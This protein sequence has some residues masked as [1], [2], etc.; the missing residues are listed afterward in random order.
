M[1]W[2]LLSHHILSYRVKFPGHINK[3]LLSSTS[4]PPRIKQQVLYCCFVPCCN[5]C[6]LVQAG[7]GR[8]S[9]EWVSSDGVGVYASFAFTLSKVIS[10]PIPRHH[11]FF[12]TVRWQ[13]TSGI[14]N[15]TQLLCLAAVD[16]LHDFNVHPLPLPQPAPLLSIW[17]ATGAGEAVAAAGRSVLVGRRTHQVAERFDPW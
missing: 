7:R 9:R 5:A 8:F 10:R 11:C 13:T 2:L 6:K 15:L 4:S 17:S 3:A 16:A 1:I 14:S 12:P